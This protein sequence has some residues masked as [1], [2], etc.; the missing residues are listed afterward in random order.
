MACHL[1]HHKYFLALLLNSIEQNV[2]S[3]QP[4][5]DVKQ[6]LNHK[7]Q[8]ISLPNKSF[9]FSCTY[10]LKRVTAFYVILTPTFNFPEI[11]N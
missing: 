2:S 9:I 3:E 5:A 11:S 7:H 4:K 10:R 1:I 6:L 8:C